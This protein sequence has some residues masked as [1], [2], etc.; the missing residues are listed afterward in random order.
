[1]TASRL[2]GHCPHLLRITLDAAL[3]S[4]KGQGHQ[5]LCSTL[6]VEGL[7]FAFCSHLKLFKVSP[8]YYIRPSNDY[9]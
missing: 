5:A 9:N 2:L 3:T 4:E 8:V 1:M 6:T 7:H